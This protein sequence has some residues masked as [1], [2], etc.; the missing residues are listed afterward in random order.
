MDAN[1]RLDHNLI[2]L[3]SEHDV[4]A[5]LEL[6]VPAGTE[7]AARPPLRLALVLDRSS[8]T[9]G[10]KLATAKR[11]ATWLASRLGEQDELALA[12]FDDTVRL[13]APLGAPAHAPAAI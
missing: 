5:M 12:D 13:L 6:S 11:C 2:S 4:H 3:E 8:S 1:I 10:P 9:S 7:S